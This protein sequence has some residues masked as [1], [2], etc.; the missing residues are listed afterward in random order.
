M[1]CELLII[2]PNITDKF[3]IKRFRE[4]ETQLIKQHKSTLKITS[5]TYFATT[6]NSRG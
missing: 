3:I 2:K 4:Q 5:Q 1:S 6:G